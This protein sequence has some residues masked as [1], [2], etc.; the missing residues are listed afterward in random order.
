MEKYKILYLTPS[1]HIFGARQSLLQLVRNLS[2]KF[3]P[4]V[5]CPEKGY[6]TQELD[7]SGIRIKYI[8][9]YPWRKGKYFL[10][11][12][13]SVLRLIRLV[14]KEK[15]DL[16]HSNEFYCNPYAV[17]ASA[18]SRI[19]VITHLRLYINP[20]MIK[21]YSLSSATKIVAVS[22]TTSKYVNGWNGRDQKVKVIYNGVDFDELKAQESREAVRKR[23][24]YTDDDFVIGHIGVFSPRKRQHTTLEIARHVV[25]ENPHCQ[26][27]LVG[28]ANKRMLSYGD[29][30]HSLLRE[31]DL[32]D[33]VTFHPISSDV[34]SLFNAIDLNL[35]ISSNEGFG[36]V[37]PEAAGFAK[38]TIGTRAGG[39][40]EV[41]RDGDTGYLVTLDDATTVARIILELASE[42]DKCT[43]MGQR[44]R[45]F[46]RTSFSIERHVE[47]VEALYEQVLNHHS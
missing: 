32:A 9:L 44:A 1:V 31:Y 29:M 36:R 4:I 33:H 42:K 26:F 40:S 18:H 19:P 16:I 12:Y 28:E 7:T 47:N 23:L 43:R 35:L 37:I 24:G 2:P 27:L 30:L 17:R 45:E 21:N 46:A 15:I 11:R 20:R 39:I 41:I 10:L 34:A 25:K 13:L 3:E 38:P 14:Q 6:L 22:N 8:P 5:V